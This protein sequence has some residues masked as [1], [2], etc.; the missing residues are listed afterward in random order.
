MTEEDKKELNKIDHAILKQVTG[1]HS[2][3]PTGQLYLETSSL[4]VTQIIAVR[5]MVYLQTILSRTEGELIRNIYEAMKEDPLPG[6]WVNMVQKDF[7]WI[8]LSISE[9]GKKICVL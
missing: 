9:E 6:D 3:A 5:R 7:E 1:S 4:S 8:N 2:K